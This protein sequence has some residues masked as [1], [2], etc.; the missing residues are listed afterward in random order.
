MSHCFING[1]KENT[2]FHS[3]DFVLEEMP[4]IENFVYEF[5]NFSSSF[6]KVTVSILVPW[7]L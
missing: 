1:K 5:K 7:I 6:L 4:Y 2:S 3:R